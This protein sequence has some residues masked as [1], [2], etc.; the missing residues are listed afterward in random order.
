MLSGNAEE[1]FIN[2]ILWKSL[3]EDTKSFLSEHLLR[4]RT[5]FI[6][7]IFKQTDL[8]PATSLTE[9]FLLIIPILQRGL[10]DNSG[11]RSI[12]EARLSKDLPSLQISDLTFLL[13]LY[14]AS[15]FQ[16]PFS[17]VSLAASIRDRLPPLSSSLP[18]N[19]RRNYSN[20]LRQISCLHS[21]ALAACSLCVPVYD[22][23]SDMSKEDSRTE[24]DETFSVKTAVEMNYAL[25]FD[26]DPVFI[27]CI[28][29]LMDI[30][31]RNLEKLQPNDLLV[32]AKSIVLKS[33]R[34]KAMNPQDYTELFS[35]LD[36]QLAKYDTQTTKIS[37]RLLETTYRYLKHSPIS[38]LKDL[39]NLSRLLESRP[40]QSTAINKVKS[41]SES[42]VK[43]MMIDMSVSILDDN[44]VM[45]DMF[46]VDV[47]VSPSLILEVNGSH[48]FCSTK[49]PD[50][51]AF[52]L[53]SKSSFDCLMGDDAVKLS[54]LTAAG[55]KAVIVDTR[56]IKTAVE[57]DDIERIKADILTALKKAGLNENSMS[58][59]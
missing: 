47:V 29:Q 24:V 7:W 22:L 45:L 13:H 43:M 20:H 17:A 4:K 49:L 44:V 50:V 48:H 19:S 1:E 5:L 8:T 14:S 32:V 55:I 2:E 15:K 41:R 6:D 39:T 38:N 40:L 36:R 33:I 9:C 53:D 28:N 25:L 58:P 37:P 3:S 54:V 18:A 34:L 11:L 59:E 57:S 42:I 16:R 27:D 46:D 52:V 35:S 21:S 26:Y 51:S 31:L 56:R 12:L 10:Y 23:L 30:V